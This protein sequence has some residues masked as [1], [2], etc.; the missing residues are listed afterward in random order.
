MRSKK[1]EIVDQ[2]EIPTIEEATEH[3]FLVDLSK[4]LV[5]PGLYFISNPDGGHFNPTLQYKNFMRF[6]KM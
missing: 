5:K 2:A 1:F 4:Y 6:M 3:Q